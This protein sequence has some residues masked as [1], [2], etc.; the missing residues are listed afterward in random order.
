[1]CVCRFLHAHTNLPTQMHTH[2]H[3]HTHTLTH[4][5]T[6]PHKC[7]HTHTHTHTHTLQVAQM[8]KFTVLVGFHGAELFNSLYMP[9]DSVTIQLIPYRARSLPVNSYAQVLKANGPYLEWQNGNERMTRP[10]EVG[11]RDNNLADTILDIDEIS[12]LVESALKL[13]VNSNLVSFSRKDGDT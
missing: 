13:G 5:L 8:Q 10:N 11:D 12:D 4:S 9:P 7:T 1:M 6:H 2:T 3:T